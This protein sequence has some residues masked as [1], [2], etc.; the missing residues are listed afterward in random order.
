MAKKERNKANGFIIN[1]DEW[2]EFLQD[3]SAEEVKD[4]LGAC[5]AYHKYRI[6]THFTDRLMKKY[7]RDM[8]RC[9]NYSDESY[10]ETCMKNAYNR[11]VGTCKSKGK[12]ILDREEWFERVYLPKHPLPSDDCDGRQLLSTD[13]TNQNEIEEKIQDKIR[14]LEETEI[15][16]ETES[17]E[18]TELE[19]GD[20]GVQGG[21]GEEP[22][23][24]NPVYRNGYQPAIPRD[25]IPLYQEYLSLREKEK[26]GEN[27]KK[28]VDLRMSLE[29]T[30][31][32]DVEKLINAGGNNCA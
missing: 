10:Y 8:V 28:M 20:R 5:I 6:P 3:S 29:K 9:M 12:E 19:K 21:K 1:D 4:M 26:T 23:P 7:F 13:A 22:I 11:Y 14:I 27:T 16:N 25:A 17:Q 2:E 15:K 30:H 31:G 32:I 18:K 24:L